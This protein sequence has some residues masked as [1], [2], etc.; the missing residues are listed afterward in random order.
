MFL[1]RSSKWSNSSGANDANQHPAG[2]A[3]A[4]GANLQQQQ[5]QQQQ[6]PHQHNHSQDK[7]KGKKSLAKKGFWRGLVSPQ[8]TKAYFLDKK[9]PNYEMPTDERSVEY[10]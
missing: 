7:T 6:Q 1:R 3:A 10:K 4:P 5:Q 2:F 8:D 9:D